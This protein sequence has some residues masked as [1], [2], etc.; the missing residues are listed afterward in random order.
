MLE[1]V[2][3]SKRQSEIRQTLATLAGK[4]NPEDTEVR[5]METL[6]KEYST[7]EVRY[8]ASLIAEDTERREAG[9]EMETR[10]GKQW[11]E[12]IGGFELRQV[13]LALDEGFQLTGR[14]AEAVS[15]LRS[16][17]GYQGIPVPLQ[18]LETRA[19]ETIG[20]GVFDPKD[21][22][23]QIDRLFPSS[24]VALTGGELIN[25]DTGLAEYPVATGGASASWAASELAD[26][27]AAVAFQ[28]IDRPLAPNHNLGCQMV[29]SRK[30]MKQSGA[31][32]EQAIRRDMNSTI[33]A[34]LDKAAFLGSGAS[35]EPLGLIPGQASYGFATTDVS[36]AATYAVFR[37]E[38][39]KFLTRNAGDYK[40][41][42]LLMRTELLDSLDDA[43]YT[44]TSVS[45]LAR[46]IDKLGAI[47][48]TTNA[49]AVPTGAPLE[50]SAVMTTSVGGIAPFYVGVWGGIDLVRDVYTKAASGQLVLTA[51]VTADVT[52]SRAAQVTILTGLQ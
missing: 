28:T 32:L 34:A 18:A 41:I 46:L 39:T 1:S 21:T 43:L 26:V 48:T 51:L 23:R 35:G 52:A 47:I 17:G 25:I 36:A 33:A 9:A 37:N 38:A 44:G 40:G 22:R 20:G 5:S 10:E 13:A 11:A 16:K 15:E 42:R 50:S 29:I 49:L 30:S 7:N 14:T 12:L 6:D 31:A 4:D 8:R 3:I 27:G 19:G 24:V 2:K 45:Q